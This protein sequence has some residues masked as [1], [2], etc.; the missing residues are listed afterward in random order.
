MSKQPQPLL[1]KPPSNRVHHDDV[2]FATFSA[3][4]NNKRVLSSKEPSSEP[5][6]NARILPNPIQT[7]NIVSPLNPVP[8]PANQ[9]QDSSNTANNWDK[10]SAQQYD[11]QPNQSPMSN[12]SPS[13]PNTPYVSS[14]LK[15]SQF[16]SLMTLE[17]MVTTSAK[18]IE[19]LLVYPSYE[20]PPSVSGLQMEQQVKPSMSPHCLFLNYQTKQGRPT[21]SK[22]SQTH[23]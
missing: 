12:M 7:T 5:K 15:P 20:I 2:M 13:Q 17:L 21:L 11:V 10:T 22:I 18:P 8:Q 6:M 3:N 16:L 4:Y 14:S 9:P 23:S 19:P 1:P